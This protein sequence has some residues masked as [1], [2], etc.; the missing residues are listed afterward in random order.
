MCLL[1]CISSKFGLLHDI[2]SAFRSKNRHV[3]CHLD[4]YSCYLPS[5]W[6]HLTPLLRHR[7]IAVILHGL[8]L[9]L[10]LLISYID[11]LENVNSKTFISGQNSLKGTSQNMEA[12]FEPALN[13]SSIPKGRLTSLHFT[14]MKHPKTMKVNGKTRSLG[15][16]SK[17]KKQNFISKRN[18]LAANCPAPLRS[19][20]WEKLVLWG[21]NKTNPEKEDFF[22]TFLEFTFFFH[23]RT[24]QRMG[25]YK[26]SA[27]SYTSS[28]WDYT[29]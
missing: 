5:S 8:L 26:H 25:S 19:M 1:L 4:K 28:Y 16:L 21:K 17:N 7:L 18:H 11:F 3:L 13:M 6:S 9:Y 15:L 23:N 24:S 20:L 29:D 10:F 2:R 22:L 14:K 12:F 27:R